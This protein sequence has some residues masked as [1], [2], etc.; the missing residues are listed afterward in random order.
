MCL[1]VELKLG[2]H[3]ALEVDADVW[4]AEDGPVH[5]EEMR[6]YLGPSLSSHN[7]Q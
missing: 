4:D 2:G 5:V 1:L 6:L 3:L 7:T